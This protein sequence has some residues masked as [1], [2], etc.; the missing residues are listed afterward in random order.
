[1]EMFKQPEALRLDGVNLE[2]AWKRWS[3]KFGNYMKASGGTDKPEEVQLAA[4]LLHIIGDEAL[5]LYN[6]FAFT[7]EAKGKI[8][9]A[10]DKFEAY[11]TV[12]QRKCSF[13]TV[14]VLALQTSRW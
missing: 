10:L 1:M 12:H 8:K 4:I 6:T 14:P 5:V 9:P 2:D 13:R 7:A 3:Q 11:R